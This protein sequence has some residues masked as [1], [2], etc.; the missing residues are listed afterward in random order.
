MAL[1]FVKVYDNSQWSTLGK[2]VSVLLNQSA[3]KFYRST[4]HMSSII[5]PETKSITAKMMASQSFENQHFSWVI[6]GL[7]VPEN[8][9]ILWSYCPSDLDLQS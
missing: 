3:P 2:V 1:C 7:S 6:H 8:F 9:D 5:I 4:I